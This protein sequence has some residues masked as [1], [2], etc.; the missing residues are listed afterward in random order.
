MR[1]AKQRSSLKQKPQKNMPKEYRYTIYTDGAS[2]LKSKEQYGGSAY[3][4]IDNKENKVISEW[5]NG[6]RFV[7]NNQCEIDAIIMAIDSLPDYST[8]L[9]FTDSQY[10]ITVLSQPDRTFPKNMLFIQEY[11][12]IQKRKH[13]FVKFQWVRGHSGNIFNEKVDRM[14]K[15][16][17]YEVEQRFKDRQD[18]TA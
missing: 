7:T 14:A 2:N 12:D 6:Y 13:I 9:I 16:A 17:M 10:A 8:C 11:R 3:I 18:E 1:K 15:Q 4:I 5:S